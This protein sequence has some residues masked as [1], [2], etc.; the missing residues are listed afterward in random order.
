MS[1]T[2]EKKTFKKKLGWGHAA[3][4]PSRTWQEEQEV[5]AGKKLGLVLHL[6]SVIND[7]Y[8]QLINVVLCIFDL[9]SREPFCSFADQCDMESP[10][11]VVPL[12]LSL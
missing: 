4:M 5:K 9:Q 7:I 6:A 2:L 3:K 11:S 1:V 12:L 8:A 10:W